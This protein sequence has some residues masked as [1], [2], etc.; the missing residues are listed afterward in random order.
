MIPQ[1]GYCTNV[2]AGADLDQTRANLDRYA[3]A[4]KQRFRPDRPMGLGLWLSAS[5]ARGLLEGDELDR[6]GDWLGQRGLV[7]FTLNGFPYGDFHRDVVKHDV[8]RPDWT[9]P[10]RLKYTRHL[11]RILHRLLP[12]RA[13]GSISTLPLMWGRPEPSPD[14]LDE[15]AANLRTLAD[16]LATL[17]GKTGR[18]IHLCIEPEPGCALDTSEDVVAFFRD[19]LFAGGDPQ[20]LRR[21][22]RIC[23]DVCHAAVMFEDQ[24]TVLQRYREVGIAVGKVQVSSAIHVPFGDLPSDQRGEALEQL[25]AFNEP[26]YLHQT[27]I[28]DGDGRPRFHDDLADALPEDPTPQHLTGRWRVHFHVPI[29]LDRIGL[30]HTSHADVLDCLRT[31]ADLPEMPHFEAETYAWSVLPEHLK[32]SELAA[33]IAAELA[34]LEQQLAGQAPQAPA[35]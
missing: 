24:H 29:Y 14:R 3:T 7:P 28:D 31:C 16:E 9:E 11:I 2:H 12:D 23:H 19:H 21:Y 6:F 30:L 32:H 34:W 8:Y 35:G 27:M 33:G 25:R 1:I 4:V 15:A 13:E 20:R 26:R 22:I 18:L 17:E 10:D 5:T